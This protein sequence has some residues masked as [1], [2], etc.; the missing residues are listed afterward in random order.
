[1]RAVKQNAKTPGIWN[2]LPYFDTVR[3]DGELGNI[4]SVDNCYKAAKSGTLPAVVWI[5]PSGPVSEHPPG[6]IP[7]GRPT[8]QV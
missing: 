3:A 1:V 8:P 2:P 7:T 4:E 6:R 5:A